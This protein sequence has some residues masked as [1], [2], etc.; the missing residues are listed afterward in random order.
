[1]EWNSLIPAAAELERACHSILLARPQVADRL[2]ARQNTVPP[3]FVVVAPPF[4]FEL[5]AQSYVPLRGAEVDVAG[6]E[7]VVVARSEHRQAPSEQRAELEP[8]RQILRRRQRVEA[9]HP[10]IAD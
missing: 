3:A 2:A 10:S 9:A 4:P 6:H 5:H 1:I 8:H 7:H